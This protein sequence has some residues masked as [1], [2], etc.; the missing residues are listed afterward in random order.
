MKFS[1]M[2]RRWFIGL[3]IL[4]SI[5][6]CSPDNDDKPI[7]SEWGE[8]IAFFKTELARLHKNLFFKV[9]KSEFESE[10][11]EFDNQI[12][13]LSDFDI[14]LKLQQVIANM[15]D[16]HTNISWFSKIDE[17][18]FLPITTYWFRDGLY[19]LETNKEYVQLLGKKIVKINNVPLTQIIDSLSTLFTVDNQALV[20]SRIPWML[21]CSQLYDFFDLGD[22][23]IYTLD[24]ES[25]DGG[26]STHQ[27]SLSNFDRNNRIALQVD[28]QSY[29]WSHKGSYF[30]SHYFEEENLFYILYNRCR[31]KESEL[32]YV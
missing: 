26:S 4:C 16:S 22:T 14:A 24:L 6:S 20:K 23:D 30:T 18:K 25:E 2:I 15:G 9:S 13:N 17:N 10:L 32:Q 31:S 12:D 29:S 19:I 5:L 27:V 11:N 8:D 28:S 7:Y 21:T 1:F 3:V